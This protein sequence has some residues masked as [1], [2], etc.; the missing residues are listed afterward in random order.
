MAAPLA[1]VSPLFA[2]FFGGCAIGRWLQQKNPGDEM[3]F[4]QNANAGALAG[5][6]TTGKNSELIIVHVCF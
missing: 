1:G 3:T 2:I 4:I 6:M 5:V